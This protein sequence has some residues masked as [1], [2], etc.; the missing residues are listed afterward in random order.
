MAV[1]DLPKVR[2][3]HLYSPTAHWTPDL[4]VAN[5]VAAVAV[6]EADAGDDGGVDDVGD[7]FVAKQMVK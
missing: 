2:T 1:D 5:V 6:V 7:D 4:I 3:D